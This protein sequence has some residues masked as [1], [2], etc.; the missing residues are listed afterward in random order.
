MY[1]LEEEKLVSRILAWGASFTTLFLITGSVTD[2]VNA[3]KLFL[4]GGVAFSVLMVMLRSN[5]R[6]HFFKDKALAFSITVF[7]IASVIATCAST[8]PLTQNLYG[9]YGRNTGLLAYICFAF[10]LVSASNLRDEKSFK[11]VSLGLLFAGMVNVL[12]SAYVLVFSDPVSWNNPYGAI[13]GT[14]GNPN[15]ISSFL[16]IFIAGTLSITLSA[17]LN[18][19][20]RVA[21]FV[22]GILAFYELSNTNSIQGYVVTAAGSAFVIYLKIRSR[23]FRALEFGY[24]LSVLLLGLTAVAGVFQHGPLSRILYQGTTAFREQYWKAAINMGSSRILTG[25]GMDAYG[26]NYRMQ[27]DIQ[28]LKTPGIQVVANTAHNVIL[29]FFASGGILL[30]ISYVSILLISAISLVRIILRSRDF[31]YVFAVL[32]ASWLGY[33][34]QSI[35]SINQIGLA[36]WGWLLSGA[37]IGYEKATRNAGIS[38][39][40]KENKIKGK[41]STSQSQVFSATLLAGLGS[42][43]G[44]ILVAPPL[45]AD[46]SW[47]QATK[48]GNLVEIEKALTPSYLHPQD[49]SRLVNVVG[50]LENNQLYDL[51]LKYAL[52]ATKYN[53]NSFDS[54]NTLYSVKNSNADQR[55]LALENMKRLDPLNPDVTK[56]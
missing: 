18:L 44:F 55:A 37:L 13:L 19:G 27:R 45:S 33:Q 26:D 28:A 14:F 24:L 38:S 2:P 42:I 25:V 10:I 12:Y 52:K 3:P 51:A 6:S 21:S 47:Y 43:F 4:A 8:S 9:T 1:S 32:A 20:L 34:L 36:I 35:I 31:D 49:S 41:K 16:G 39:P 22:F 53:P 7:I 46:M 48:S 11:M 56:R 54:W 23:G 29:D 40:S 15:F 17:E 30:L 50:L 5:A